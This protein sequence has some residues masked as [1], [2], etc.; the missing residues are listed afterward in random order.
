M[1]SFDDFFM[2]LYAQLLIDIRV[3]VCQDK[4]I[5]SCLLLMVLISITGQRPWRIAQEITYMHTVIYNSSV[6]IAMLSPTHEIHSRLVC[7]TRY[8]VK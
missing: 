6:I 8:F 5:F 7:L 3:K 1:H 4:H 2:E